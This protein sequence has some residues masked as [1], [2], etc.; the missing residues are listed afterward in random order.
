MSESSPNLSGSCAICGQ[1]NVET[2]ETHHVVPRRYGGSGSPENLVKLCGSCHNAVEKI[3]D[4]EFYHRLGQQEVN[5][6]AGT[7]DEEVG[8]QLERRD[9][10]D[11]DIPDHTKHVSRGRKSVYRLLEKT[12]IQE[13]DLPSHKT[14]AEVSI[15][16]LKEELREDDEESDSVTAET[17]SLLEEHDEYF[18]SK[19][20]AEYLKEDDSTA[21]ISPRIE[22][23]HC[24]Y[25]QRAFFPW[26]NADCARHLQ[27]AHHVNDPYQS[28][29]SEKD[30][31]GPTIT[32][33]VESDPVVG[34]G[35]SER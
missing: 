10:P 17:I 3:Y 22:L 9:T 19:E 32:E 1:T 18:V 2:L 30:N 21:F 20:H 33:R 26:E 7:E 12:D 4:D 28:H 24:G 16:T 8:V 15:E 31:Q 23:M 35:V 13:E 34:E 25:C 11:R 27:T 14:P 5:L 29:P 6:T